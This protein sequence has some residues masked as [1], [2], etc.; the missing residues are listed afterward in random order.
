MA[1]A[2]IWYYMATKWYFLVFFYLKRLFKNI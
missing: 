1:M 2:T